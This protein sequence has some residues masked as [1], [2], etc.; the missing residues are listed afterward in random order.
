MISDRPA[1]ECTANRTP[2]PRAARNVVKGESSL[3]GVAG[4]TNTIATSRGPGLISAA[5]ESAHFSEKYG[6]IGNPTDRCAVIRTVPNLLW[7]TAPTG[8]SA[9]MLTNSV[10]AKR[11]D[12]FSARSASNIG[13]VRYSVFEP[14]TE[15][16]VQMGKQS[17]SSPERRSFLT[18]LNAGVASLAAMAFGGV[19][20]A[21][22]KLT[23]TSR[24]EPARHEK[25]DW[26]DQTCQAEWR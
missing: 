9:S 2:T 1:S 14:R 4:R 22:V 21:Q 13:V 7:Y 10:P 5:R 8:M 12:S 26:F 19:A 18:S 16:D 15:S 17:S 25:D 24:W 20:A 11:T 6:P 3:G 23:A